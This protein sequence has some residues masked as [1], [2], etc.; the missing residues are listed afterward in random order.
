M[1]RRAETVLC[2]LDADAQMA[3]V[4]E[5]IGH[6]DKVLQQARS[7]REGMRML[8]EL[9]PDL[10]IVSLELPEM[11]GPRVVRH[12]RESHPTSKVV[13]LTAH[14]NTGAAVATMRAG[15]EDYLTFPLDSERLEQAVGRSLRDL[16]AERALRETQDQMRD[17]FGFHDLLSRS[18]R[19]LQVFEQIRA[20]APTDATVL[21]LGE[22][23]TGKELVARAIHDGSRRKQKQ[24]ISVNC[25][26]FS[27]S[28]LESELFGHERGS[29][30]GAV[31]RREG[32]FM[33][34]DGGTL[35]LDE[36]GTTS[37]N[38]QVKL[39]RV[40]E[41]MSFRR[42]GGDKLVNVDVR[43]VA[44]TNLDLEDAVERGE[45]RDD[46]FYRLNVFPI[47]LP[48]LRERAED[49][50]LLLQHFV[51]HISDEYGLKPPIIAAD[52]LA[53]IQLYDWPGN[54]RQLRAMVERWVIVSH[55]RTLLREMLPASM[56]DPG[57]PSDGG[58]GASFSGGFGVDE[59]EPLAP[60]L[61]RVQEQFERAYLHKVLLREGGHLQRTAQRTGFTRRTLYSKMKAYGM[62][63]G[64]YRRG[65][66]DDEG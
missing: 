36:L 9:D 3:Q 5:L 40:L 65:G 59:Q 21:I 45:F 42:V 53:A 8:D 58:G 39:L 60:Q 13:A 18:P 41:E 28:L 12:V 47:H 29:F 19:M 6:G 34:A 63:P 26:A 50:P 46:L 22:T 33:Q 30:T 49:I 48:P 35:F 37:L 56:Q 51:R 11:S 20:V 1:T 44:A 24:Y 57:M 7:L 14:P 4:R 32:V 52:A 15:G 27:E 61:Q 17:R 2:I 31:E 54:V 10:V 66:R 43:I 38:L 23:G 64:E 55:G 62:D 16:R 25:G